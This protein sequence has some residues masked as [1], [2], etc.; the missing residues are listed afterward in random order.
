M[1]TTLSGAIGPRVDEPGLDRLQVRAAA[2]LNEHTNAGGRCAACPGGV[3]FPCPSAVM[4]EHNA[5][6]R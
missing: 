2:V 1:P 3:P 5:A 6:L 4:A